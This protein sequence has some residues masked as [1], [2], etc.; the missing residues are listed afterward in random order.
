METRKAQSELENNLERD[1]KDTVEVGN[2]Q[3]KGNKDSNLSIG[4]HS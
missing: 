3:H 4:S 1:V 2:R